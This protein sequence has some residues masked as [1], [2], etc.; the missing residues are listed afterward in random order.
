MKIGSWSARSIIISIITVSTTY[1]NNFLNNSDFLGLLLNTAN[2]T[3][4]NN[5]IAAYSN[6]GIWQAASSF[7]RLS[8]ISLLANNMNL[9]NN[10][11]NSFEN[12]Q[13]VIVNNVNILQV[14]YKN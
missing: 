9:R 12:L 8:N 7:Y 3:V 6:W 5:T 14:S 13:F 2:A 1:T 11:N 10:A 4:A